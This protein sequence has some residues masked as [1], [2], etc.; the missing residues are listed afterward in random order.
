MVLFYKAK[1]KGILVKIMLNA[2]NVRENVIE[3]TV[4]SIPTMPS[5]FG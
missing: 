1:K 4:I 2:D 5:L 3:S